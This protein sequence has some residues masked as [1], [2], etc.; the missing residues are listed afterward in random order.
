MGFFQSI[1]SA[2][3]AR[4][5][6]GQ[7]RQGTARGQANPHFV[8]KAKKATMNPMG[9]SVDAEDMVQYLTRR[10]PCRQALPLCSFSMNKRL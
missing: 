7:W 9:T 1:R 2:R 8:A 4:Q 5:E 10:R 3:A 6:Q